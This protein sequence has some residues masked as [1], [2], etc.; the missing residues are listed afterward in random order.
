[1]IAHR[2][3]LRSVFF[4]LAVLS[5]LTNSCAP[6]KPTL[7]IS[8]PTNWLV[9]TSLMI[10]SA[11][12]WSLW[13]NGTQL[14]GA[15]IYQRRV[16]PEFDGT[17]FIGPGPF[18][19]PYTQAD[20]DRLAS[21]GANYVNISGPGLFTIEQ[22]YEVDEEAVVNLDRLLEMAA[23]ADIFAVITFRTGPGRSEFSILGPADWLPNSLII[24]TVWTDADARNAWAEMWRYAAERYRDNTIVVGYDL[25]CEP[26]SNGILDIWDAKTFYASYAGTGYDWNAW[27]PNLV[28]AI[29]V[30]DKHTPIL[31]GGNNFSDV[32]WLPY[33]QPVNDPYIVYMIH[34]YSPHEYTHQEPPQLTRSYPGNFDT[35]YDGSSETFDRAWLDNLLA[36]A[37]DFQ[38]T[39][40][41]VLA[42]NEYG[43]ERW[44]PGGADYVRDE[45][46]LFE[47]HGWNYAVW[48]WH[49][50]W[51][52]LAEGDHGFNFLFGS[53]PANL[54]EIPNDL[55]GAYTTAWARNIIR[56]SNFG[57]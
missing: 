8:T 34:Q 32:D 19:P 40:K 29:R 44:E 6:M 31:V 7:A 2:R 42:V 3:F 16:Y 1:M 13:I 4:T 24:Q 45:M 10:S 50:S 52:P 20:F 30:V 35:N 51:P 23:K 33:F 9:P 36:I 27:Y 39:Q 14:R 11:E 48:Q 49:A 21:L 46:A 55:M 28:S 5:V 17:E 38:S 47:Q 56:P 57:K 41:A 54:T 22:P 26:N 18:G 25:M 53:D 37:V 12:R 15:N 43:L